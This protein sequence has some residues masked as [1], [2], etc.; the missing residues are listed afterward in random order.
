MEQEK[1]KITIHI[2]T[3]LGCDWREDEYSIYFINSTQSLYMGIQ[4]KDEDDFSLIRDAIRENMESFNLPPEGM[5]EVVLIEDG[6][7]EDV[8][9]HK[10]FTVE[11]FKFI[12]F[13]EQENDI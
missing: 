1:N 4:D 3:E 13:E 7:W 5:T 6:E 12:P 8:F 2:R 10:Y 11:S 9:F